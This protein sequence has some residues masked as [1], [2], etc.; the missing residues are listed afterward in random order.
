MKFADIWNQLRKKDDK[1]DD[2]E[3]DVVFKSKNLKRLLEQVYAQGQ[4]S[5]PKPKDP[6]PSKG[7]GSFMDDIFGPG[8]GR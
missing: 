5:V 6:P 1:L 7:S 3:A 2:P 8:F 4:K